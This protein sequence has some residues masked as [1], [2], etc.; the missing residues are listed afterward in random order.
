M[1]ITNR[2]DALAALGALLPAAM[3]APFS[4]S[5][6]AQAGYPT[7]P[8]KMIVPFGAG[9]SP[10]IIARYLSQ[11]LQERLGQP[12]VVDNKAGAGG[13]LGAE[14]AARSA[15]DG[16]TLIFMVN[17]IVTMNPFLYKKLG[18]DPAKDFAP[19][20]LLTSVPY[21]LLAHKDFRA[22][23]LKDLIAMARAKPGGIDYASAGVGGAGH[24]IME[25]MCSLA[26]VQ[27]THIP[28][29][30]D[31]LAAVIGGQVPLM[32]QPTTTAVPQIKSGKLI[33]L[34]TTSTKRLAV[35]PDVPPIAEVVPGFAADGW[36]GLM[37][38]AGTPPAIV[39]R[40][41]A[42]V[43]AILGLPETTERLSALAIEAWPSTPQQMQATIATDTAKWGKVIADAR[44]E[45]Q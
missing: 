26:G 28:Y 25:L 20:S 16:Y 45:A 13:A 2:R 6:C 12:F 42:E 8:V 37:A 5:A 9:S 24:V 38:P 27:M 36:Q 11:K 3:G 23:T 19:I 21:V 40:L 43:A 17:S 31:G 39:E 14:A 33:G 22:R 18:Y 7:K 15:P 10:D 30:T 32:V 41:R 35:L 29:K 1:R 44:I 4:S 34:G